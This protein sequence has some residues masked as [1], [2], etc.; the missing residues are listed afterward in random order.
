MSKGYYLSKL[1]KDTQRAEGAVESLFFS[2]EEEE[3]SSKAKDDKE[4]VTVDTGKDG[5]ASGL[6]FSE[7]G[8]SKRRLTFDKNSMAL[9]ALQ[10]GKVD[11]SDDRVK[12]KGA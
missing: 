6:T 5:L 2:F 8:A 11:F 4:L 3:K 12:I 1:Y 7:G 10:E 9:Q